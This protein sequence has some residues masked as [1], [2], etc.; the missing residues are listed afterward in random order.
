VG[1]SS[2]G[3]HD[4]GDPVG[5]TVDDFHAYMPAHKYLYRP[6]NELWP[7]SSV[8]SKLAPVPVKNARGE[9]VLDANGKPKL[10]LAATWLDT[11]RSVEQMTWAPGEPELIRDRH[12]CHHV[13]SLSAA[14][15]RAWR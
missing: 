13:Q 10:M 11:F 6:T 12:L 8:N 9:P 1:E 3:D 4:L 7:A 5:V 2:N 14:D 15:P